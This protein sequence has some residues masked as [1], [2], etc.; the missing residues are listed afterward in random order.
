MSERPG[1]SDVE[2]AA[3]VIFER[4]WQA[5]GALFSEGQAIWTSSQANELHENFVLRPDVSGD[6]FMTKFRAQLEPASDGARQLAAELLYLNLLPLSDYFGSK[7]RE[8]ITTVLGW[9]QASPTIPKDLD[10]ALDQ[11]VFNGG[12]A[13][14]TRRWNQLALLI[15]LIRQFKDLSTEERRRLLADPWS[16]RDFIRGAD[17]PHEPAQRNSVLYLAF[18]DVFL[19]IV[20][21]D[22][23]R[24]I[25]KAFHEYLEAPA[26]DLDRDLYAI[27]QALNAQAD[28]HAD[29]Y[30]SPWRKRWL[31][32]AEPDV[33]EAEADSGGE[34][35]RA[36]LVRGSSVRGRDLVPTWLEQNFVSL[37]ASRLPALD[38]DLDRDAI[39]ALV[40]EHYSDVSYNQRQQKSDE[41]Y[42][43]L[44]RM[45]TGDLVTTTSQGRLY[46]GRIT[47]DAS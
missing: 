7:K 1:A 4:G 47:S 9:T 15:E 20:S 13:F 27:Q 16:F 35:R 2:S 14:K 5:D 43:F 18:P 30:R 11:G 24:R 26:G 6:D 33:P 36:W 22:H 8:I 23:R 25:V 42:S 21:S 32:P 39:K 41:L 17:G 40:D 31:T 29:F 45:H 46:V 37:Q 19:P 12:V 28:G 34:V 38:P 44:T 3:R 10:A